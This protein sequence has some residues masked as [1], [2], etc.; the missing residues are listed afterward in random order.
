MR[1]ERE[2]AVGLG[3]FPAEPQRLGRDAE[4]VLMKRGDLR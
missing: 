4:L 1:I 3:I 2:S